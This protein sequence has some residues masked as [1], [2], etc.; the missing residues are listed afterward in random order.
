MRITGIEPISSVWKTENLPLIYIRIYTFFLEYL[1]SPKI[2]GGKS[3]LYLM[4]VNNL[5]EKS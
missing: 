4:E 5:Q 2:L 1:C 3:E